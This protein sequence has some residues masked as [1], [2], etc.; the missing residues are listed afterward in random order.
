MEAARLVERELMLR[1]VA[2]R[3][4]AYKVDITGNQYM[5]AS[6]S[7]CFNCVFWLYRT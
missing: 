4:N 2:G 1:H 7:N 5:R 3:Q 6:I